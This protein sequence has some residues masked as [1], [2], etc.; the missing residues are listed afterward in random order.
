MSNLQIDKPRRVEAVSYAGPEPTH[1][2]L[3]GYGLWIFGFLGLH[4]FYYGKPFTGLLWLLTGGVFLI[5]WVI[6]FFLIPSM[7]REAELRYTRGEV[8][9]SLAWLLLIFLGLFGVH[10][11]YLGK[12]ITGIVWLCT[13]ALCGFGLVYDFATLNEQV[14]EVNVTAARH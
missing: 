6:D 2:V 12:W 4:R 11:F 8:D 13:G 14:N 7:A 10:R 9:Y 5:G 1:S 3:V